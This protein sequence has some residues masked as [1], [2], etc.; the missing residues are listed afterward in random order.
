MGMGTCS[1]E[2]AEN[3]HQ[4]IAAVTI[5]DHTL[6]KKKEGSVE[7]LNLNT[8]ECLRGRLLAERQASR[9]A[10]EQAESMDEKL[11][12]LE[13]MIREEIK[14]RERAQRKL[15]FLTKKLETLNISSISMQS[16]H[17]DY[18][19][20]NSCGSSS[21]SV[22]SISKHSSEVNDETKH[23]HHHHEKNED[24]PENNNEVV[25]SNNNV[26]EEASAPIQ[27]Y[28]STT[29]DSDSEISFYNSNSSSEDLKNDER[30]RISSISSKSSVTEKEDDEKGYFI[31]NSMAL[32]PVNVITTS[33]ATS[34]RPKPV[35]QSVLEALEALKHAKKRLQSSM[36][37][38]QMIHVGPTPTYN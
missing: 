11:I 38:R 4:V 7:G 20:E 13:T 3:M 8:V 14:L 36:E 18:S 21:S 16:H 5:E 2:I 24:L 23:H 17:S 27:I 31:D 15:R 26:T 34:N 29:K 6:S 22:T 19:C 32:V 37:T 30:S 12:E 35:N 10:K 25:H 1:G 28:P 9:V 33:Q